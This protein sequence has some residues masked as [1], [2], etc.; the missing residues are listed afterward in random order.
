M[1]MDPCRRKGLRILSGAGVFESFQR[2]GFMNL[3]RGRSFR[4]LSGVRGL[5]ILSRVKGF[6]ILSEQGVKQKEAK[7]YFKSRG[8]GIFSEVW[9]FRILS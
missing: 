6:R 2:Q 9:D 3:L 8:S 1:F 4:I 5:M 7:V